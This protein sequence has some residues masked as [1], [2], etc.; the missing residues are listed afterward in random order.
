MDSGIARRYRNANLL[1][2]V[3]CPGEIATHSNNTIDALPANGREGFYAPSSVEDRPMRSCLIALLG[4][5]LPFAAFANETAT[6]DANDW[7]KDH[8]QWSAEQTRWHGEHADALKVLKRAERAIR[9][10]E[11][12]IR[13][14]TKHIRDHEAALR[15]TDRG[16]ARAEKGLKRWAEKHAAFREEHARRQATHQKIADAIATLKAAIAD[17]KR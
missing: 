15:R 7:K 1:E 14:H 12:A 5:S 8:A 17:E 11:R 9:A 3:R 2:L 6:A 13:R 16:N 4:L 10:H